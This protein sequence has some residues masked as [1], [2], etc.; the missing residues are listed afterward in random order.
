VVVVV[1]VAAAALV[2]GA[3]VLVVCFTAR[4]EDQYPL[5]RRLGGPPEPVW[6]FN[7]RGLLPLLG[8]KS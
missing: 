2:D 1:L 5:N 8:Y 7:G 6:T 4:K 3:G